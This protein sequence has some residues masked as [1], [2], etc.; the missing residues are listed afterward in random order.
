MSDLGK[1]R[2]KKNRVVLLRMLSMLL[3]CGMLVGFAGSAMSTPMKVYAEEEVVSEETEL[4]TPQIEVRPLTFKDWFGLVFCIA[5]GIGVCLWVAFYGD[6]K[7][8]ERLRNKKIKEQ[9]AQEAA[10]KAAREA[11]LKKK[12][13]EVQTEGSEAKDATEE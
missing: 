4:V 5:L 8:R 1:I 3:L 9:M 6:P 12:E 13:E 2:E 10:R 7:E 11:L